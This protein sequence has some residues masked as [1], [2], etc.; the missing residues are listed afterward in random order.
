MI[1]G[2]SNRILVRSSIISQGVFPQFYGHFKR[3]RDPLSMSSFCS[4]SIEPNHSSAQSHYENHSADTYDSAYFY[5]VGAYTKHLRDLC[6]S[7]LQFG[8]P[9]TSSALD[10]RNPTK[11]PSSERILLDIGG[12]TGTFT[13]MLIQDTDCRAVVVDPFLEHKSEGDERN[14]QVM[15][16]RAQAEAFIED[17]NNS[18]DVTND[19]RRNFHQILLKEVAHHFADQDRVRMFRGMYSGLIPTTSV[20]PSLLLITRPQ[21][22]IDYPL[23][24]EA[25]AV[26]ALNQPSVEQ[27]VSELEA[28]GFVNVSYTVEKYPCSIHL[29]R[30]Q[31]MILARFWST[32]ANFTDEQ[33]VE[34]C[35]SI[36]KNEKH[37]ITAD[38]NLHFEDR[39]IFITASKK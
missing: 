38:G 18:F 8:V 39:L 5:E 2:S 13:R 26:W 17:P 20:S 16:V 11:H 33:L 23:W 14:D 21:R 22:D 36:A 35:L 30:W 3:K 7:R 6:R 9:W 31:S 27:F 28:A 1:S 25:K 24:D 37:R 15:F 10:A 29:E 4:R 34:A 19:W 12:G 32:F